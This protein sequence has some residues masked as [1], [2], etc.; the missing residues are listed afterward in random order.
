MNVSQ[1]ER[2]DY[3]RKTLVDM[4]P[5]RI[6][7]SIALALLFALPVTAAED[8]KKPE[9][10]K[11]AKKETSKKAATNKPTP[12]KTPAKKAPAKKP[13]AKKPAPKKP[14]PKPQP[15]SVFADKNLEKAVRRQVFAKRNTTD[16]LTAA[17][18]AQVA[19]VQGR[20]MGI[21][22]LSGLEHCKS[23]ASLDLAGNQIKDLTPIKGLP[24]LQQLI[25]HTN[26]VESLA[27]LTD[28]S[29]LQYIDLNHNRLKDI[30][31]L[32]GL[33]NLSVLYV[34][35]NQVRNIAPITG[36]PKLHSFYVDRNGLASV[37]G[38]SKLRWL[39]SFSASG[40][41]IKDLKPLVG[42]ENLSFLFLERNKISDL[43]PLFKMITDDYKGKQRFSPFVRIYLKNNP[44]SDKA[45]AGMKEFTKKYYTR[46]K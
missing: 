24:R 29:A 43:G 4:K 16:P 41:Q 39:S 37:A 32:A 5:H 23:L 45:K 30:K 38:L 9:K 44:L 18:V 20:N 42:L 34:S 17:D 35:D 22:S 31:P 6:I 25:L 33:T 10:P 11:P 27:P 28:N 26:L 40:N 46:F 3:N 15:K 2:S 8:K 36:L 14:A 19:I 1:R 7:L 12:K 21:K 13:V